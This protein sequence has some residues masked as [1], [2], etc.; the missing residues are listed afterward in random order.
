MTIIEFFD[1]CDFNNLTLKEKVSKTSILMDSPLE[2]DG[3]REPF[4]EK[5]PSC[6]EIL[7]CLHQNNFD[8]DKTYSYLLS[9]NRNERL[10]SII[11][12]S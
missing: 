1:S 12:E 5:F 8:P 10:N 11:D 2:W 7:R 3:L 4:L 9:K 6:L